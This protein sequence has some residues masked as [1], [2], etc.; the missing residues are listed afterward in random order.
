M[1]LLVDNYDSFTYNLV[2]LLQELG[3][4]V[5]VRRNDEIDADEAES[6]GPSHLVV[7]PGPGRPEQSGATLDVSAGSRRRRRRSASASATRR[8]SRPSGRDRPGSTAPARQDEPDPP[9]RR[10]ASSPGCRRTSPPADTTRCPRPAYPSP[11]PSRRGATT[12][13][14]WASATGSCWWT[15]CSSI[16][17]RC[18]RFRSGA[19]SCEISWSDDPGQPQPRP[20]RPRPEPRRGLRGDDRDHARRGHACAD[21]RLPRSAA[22]QGRDGGRDRRLRRRDARARA[23][24]EAP[25]RR[26]RGHGG[27]RRRRREDVEHL[28]RGRARRSGG[29]RRRGQARQPRRVLGLGVG[30]RPGGARLRSSN[31]RRNESRARSTSSASASC[32]RRRTIRPCGT[33]PRCGRSWPRGPSSTCS[34]R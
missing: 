5:V 24:G 16:P 9:R 29:R 12:A 6:L 8:S 4:E 28:H 30:R 18:S 1:I 20:R 34:G 7:S 3:A 23:G 22:G 14:S 33:R 17:S 11:R 25:A 31:S 19:T 10:K 2:H 26:P 13:R 27:H 15:A 32:S 21:R